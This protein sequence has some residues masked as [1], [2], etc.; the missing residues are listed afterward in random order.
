MCLGESDPSDRATPTAVPER[1]N[2]I[3]GTDPV[4]GW[5]ELFLDPAVRRRV[6][7]VIA[8]AAKREPPKC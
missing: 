2:K 3:S 1:A 6:G 4:P 7:P 8:G 5:D